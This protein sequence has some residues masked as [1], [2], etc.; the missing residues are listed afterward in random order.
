M[1]IS[2]VRAFFVGTEKED[3]ICEF[4]VSSAT[5][6]LAA[7]AL[8]VEEARI[9]KTLAFQHKEGGC[10]LVVAAGD[11]KIS[12]RKFKDR[13]S[14]KPRMMSP[15]DTAAATGHTVGGVCPFALPEQ[16]VEVYCDNSLRRFDIVYPAAG[17]AN[18]AIPMTCGELFQ[19]SGALAWIDV[20]DLPEA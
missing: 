7:K 16:G 9:A 10:L 17:S 13:F 8:D 12:N 18:S 11:A 6:A 1:S 2:S 15:E 20:C 19:Y 14:F 5:V 3:F 4:P